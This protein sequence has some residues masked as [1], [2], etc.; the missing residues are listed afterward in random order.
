MKDVLKK[1]KDP[2]L[3]FQIERVSSSCEAMEVGRVGSTAGQ[4]KLRGSLAI[5]WGDHG[6]SP[7]AHGLN[8]E[9]TVYVNDLACHIFPIF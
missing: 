8:V 9:S 7:M 4:Q 1:I 2:Y 3:L 5:Y 6:F